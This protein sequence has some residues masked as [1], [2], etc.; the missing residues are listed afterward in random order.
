[1]N[2]AFFDIFGFFGF[3]ILFAIGI[4]ML[5][6]KRKLPDWVSIMVIAIALIGLLIDA[7]NVITNFIV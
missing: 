3:L 7:Y 2:A 6:S 4:K 5:T 1:M